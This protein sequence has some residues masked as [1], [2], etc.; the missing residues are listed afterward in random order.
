MSEFGNLTS[1]ILGS[2]DGYITPDLVAELKSY[3]L[4]EYPKSV[5]TLL[6]M[7]TLTTLCTPSV[8]AMILTTSDLIIG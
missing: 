8:F 7:T 2:N 6:F 5:S 3:E 1:N 4:P